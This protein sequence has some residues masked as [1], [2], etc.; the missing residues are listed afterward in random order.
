MSQ[1]KKNLKRKRQE[2]PQQKPMKKQ[3]PETPMLTCQLCLRKRKKTKFATCEIC[4]EPL[5]CTRRKCGPTDENY[6]EYSKKFSS[7]K[8]CNS[9]G[10][11]GCYRHVT[12]ETIENEK[13]EDSYCTNCHK[14]NLI[15]NANMA[16]INHCVDKLKEGIIYHG[17]ITIVL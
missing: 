3:K 7:C 17:E 1:I 14:A 16:M 4:D 9:L 11:Y 15:C 6:E 13:T 10:C 2:E 5:H 8:E 12:N